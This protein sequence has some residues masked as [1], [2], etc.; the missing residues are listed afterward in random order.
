MATTL[1]NIV[2]ISSPTC[3]QPETKI[4]R[5]MSLCLHKDSLRHASPAL[6]GMVVHIS[7]GPSSVAVTEYDNYRQIHLLAPMQKH[8]PADTLCTSIETLNLKDFMLLC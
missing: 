5:E 7:V 4:S 3:E 8:M 2:G 1:S 6:L